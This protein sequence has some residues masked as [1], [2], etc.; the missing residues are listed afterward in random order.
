MF[1]SCDFDFKLLFSVSR[2]RFHKFGG[3]FV[4]LA[5]LMTSQPWGFCNFHT[6][7][8]A[9]EGE[10]PGWVGNKMAVSES[11]KINLRSL[12]GNTGKLVR[13]PF[14]VRTGQRGV[15]DGRWELSN[16]RSRVE[17]NPKTVAPTGVPDRYCRASQPFNQQVA[18]VEKK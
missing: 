7:K 15:C 2:A 10:E 12:W 5:A 16:W 17:S 18:D 4:F 9:G 8:H 1:Y 14:R 3:F 13:D 11:L 6:V